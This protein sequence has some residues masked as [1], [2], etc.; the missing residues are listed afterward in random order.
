[1]KTSHPR[2]RRLWRI[3]YVAMIALGIFTV[4]VASGC[5]ILGFCCVQFNKSTLKN[6]PPVWHSRLTPLVQAD[7][8]ELIA[9]HDD[10]SRKTYEAIICIPSP[11]ARAAF[12]ANIA[13]RRPKAPKH[14]ISNT[15]LY[16]RFTAEY[17]TRAWAH[18]FDLYAGCPYGKD[19]NHPVRVIPGRENTYYVHYTES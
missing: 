4:L 19:K 11:E 12:E 9:A 16:Q 1:M 15:P 10:R 8:V 7:E 13:A 18:D 2:L 14:T 17:S 6:Q 5:S 3:Y